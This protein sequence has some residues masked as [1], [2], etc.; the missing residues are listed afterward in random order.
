[1]ETS[2]ERLKQYRSILQHITDGLLTWKNPETGE[3]EPYLEHQ[4]SDTL[5]IFLLKGKMPHIYGE[6]QEQPVTQN[7][8]QQINQSIINLVAICDELGI[9]IDPEELAEIE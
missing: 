7:V 8:E 2:P 1:V 3:V 4:Y 9:E 6:K 5:L